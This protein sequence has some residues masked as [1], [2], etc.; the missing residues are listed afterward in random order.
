MSVGRG[1][2]FCPR[3]TSSSLPLGKSCN[4]LKAWF[5][6]SHLYFIWFSIWGKWRP[7][8]VKWLGQGW[9]ACEWQGKDCRRVGNLPT[10]WCSLPDTHIQKSFKHTWVRVRAVP[11]LCWLGHD[12][13]LCWEESLTSFSYSDRDLQTW[14]SSCVYKVALG[15]R[16]NLDIM[17]YCKNRLCQSVSQWITHCC[18]NKGWWEQ[19]HVIFNKNKGCQPW[20]DFLHSIIIPI[21]WRD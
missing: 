12:N 2:V 15:K 1:P 18:G 17:H 9:T 14:L 5:C 10:S 6:F 20:H 16:I 13:L 19:D 7:R 3:S 4:Q 8:K 21:S 11:P